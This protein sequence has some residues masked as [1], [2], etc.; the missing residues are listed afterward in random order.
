[1]LASYSMC[2][3]RRTMSDSGKVARCDAE[4]PGDAHPPA[5]NSGTGRLRALR[6]LFWQLL[7]V[8]VGFSA[9]YFL[10]TRN[11]LA[12]DRQIAPPLMLTS[13][14]GRTIDLHA[15]DDT[16]TLVYFFAPWC[17]V[18]AASA[19]N[20][21]SIRRSMGDDELSIVLVALDWQDEAEVRQYAERHDLRDLVLLGNR[22][23]A[24]DWH[25]FGFPTYYVVDSEH[26]VVR[27]DFGYSSYF[28]LWWRTR[29]AE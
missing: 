25:V 27:K 14:Q 3:F 1:M 4:M 10:Q 12:T 9:I 22:Q 19:H 5:R 21:R 6:D 28:G 29:F 11:L 7:F 13:L 16:P 15:A 20:L 17:H 26:R 18:C 24:S 23:V 2:S 8:A